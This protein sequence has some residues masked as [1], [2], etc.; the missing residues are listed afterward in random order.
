MRNNL[1]RLDEDR[2][3]VEQL[4][5]LLGCWQHGGPGIALALL[6]YPVLSNERNN[7]ALG[8][9]CAPSSFPS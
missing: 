5:L 1:L 3:L 8:L 9:W 7:F 6:M 4:R 2:I